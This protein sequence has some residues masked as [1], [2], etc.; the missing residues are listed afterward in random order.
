MTDGWEH[1]AMTLRPQLMT[2]TD[3]DNTVSA[4]T[5]LLGCRERYGVLAQGTERELEHLLDEAAKEQTVRR[6]ISVSKDVT[7]SRD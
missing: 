4:L 6:E 1:A 2:G 3:L 5:H 7:A